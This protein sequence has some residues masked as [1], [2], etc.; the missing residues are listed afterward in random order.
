MKRFFTFLCFLLVSISI[1]QA[2]NQCC[3]LNDETYKGY[4]VT[5]DGKKLTGR[6]GEIFYS[7]ELSIVLFI[8]DFGTPYHLQAELITGFVFEREQELV[9]YESL[10]KNKARTWTFFKVMHRGAVLSLFKSPEEKL[11]FTLSED[12]MTGQKINTNEY[13]LKMKGERSFKLNR[14]GYKRVLK[15]HLYNYPSVTKKIGKPGY[16]FK[17]LETI[18]QEVNDIYS[19]KKRIL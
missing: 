18:V 13:W 6:I 11:E 16:K 15:K 19:Y 12:G 1:V 8:N 2:N 17:D 10:F 3:S 5:L 14:L 9:E 4:I 7:D